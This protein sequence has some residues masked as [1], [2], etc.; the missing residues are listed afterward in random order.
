MGG[1]R[2]PGRHLDEK[3]ETSEEV[4][5]P[6]WTLRAVWRLWSSASVSDELRTRLIVEQTLPLKMCDVLSSEGQKKSQPLLTLPGDL[7]TERDGGWML[8][9]HPDLYQSPIQHVTVA[10]VSI[11]LI[12]PCK[13][14]W[15]TVTPLP[16]SLDPRATAEPRGDCF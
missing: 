11:S 6:R 15:E 12:S 4:L 16:H 9:K 3:G 8:L 10:R 1:T 7:W 14:N 13:C 2:P 5:L